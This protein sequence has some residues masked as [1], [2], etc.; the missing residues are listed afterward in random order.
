[1]KPFDGVGKDFANA[2][3]TG[4]CPNESD[5]PDLPSKKLKRSLRK[6]SKRKVSLLVACSLSLR[7]LPYHVQC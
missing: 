2:L 7:S 3:T 6:Q 4:F 1:V 5:F